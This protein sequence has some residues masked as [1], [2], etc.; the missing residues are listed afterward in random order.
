[1]NLIGSLIQISTVTLDFGQLRAL[2]TLFQI[3]LL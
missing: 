2:A 1:M 3:L